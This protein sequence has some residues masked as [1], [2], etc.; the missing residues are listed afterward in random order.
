MPTAT[1]F[2]YHKSFS[3]DAHCIESKTSSQLNAM[4]LSRWEGTLAEVM[5]L[6]WNLYTVDIAITVSGHAQESHTSSAVGEILGSFD[7]LPGEGAIPVKAP[8]DRVCMTSFG[9]TDASEGFYLG[10]YFDDFN[11]DDGG[12]FTIT[13]VK[14]YYNSSTTKYALMYHPHWFSSSGTL[15]ATVNPNLDT[16]LEGV[17]TGSAMTNEFLGQQI[18]GWRK[19]SLIADFEIIISNPVYYTY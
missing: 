2:I 6:W 7:G 5:A 8:R 9:G 11:G 17:D 1:A 10:E 12:M 19:A 14:V 4:V 16:A 13:F 18:Y 15:Y 3:P